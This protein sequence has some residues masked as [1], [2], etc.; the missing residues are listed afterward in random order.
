MIGSPTRTTWNGRGIILQMNGERVAEHAKITK[1]G[2]ERREGKA[3]KKDERI[4]LQMSE[5]NIRTP[6][7]LSLH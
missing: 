3:S 6:V 4:L 1:A 2:D 7:N 5:L